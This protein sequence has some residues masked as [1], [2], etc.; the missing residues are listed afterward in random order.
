MAKYE[1]S[2]SALPG[3][4]EEGVLKGSLDQLLRA[5]VGYT[6]VFFSLLL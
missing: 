6:Q 3:N 4:L 1:E 5:G 2:S